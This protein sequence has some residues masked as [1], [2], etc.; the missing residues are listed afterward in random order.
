MS[1]P[2]TYCTACKKEFN[3]MSAFEHH[4]N[5]KHP[6]TTFTCNVCDLTYP[7][8]AGYRKHYQTVHVKHQHTCNSCGKS[9]AYK[10]LLIDHK[11]THSGDYP[12][13]CEEEGCGCVY[14]TKAALKIHMEVH[15]ENVHQCQKCTFV[16]D[17]AQNLKQHMMSHEKKKKCPECDF[18]YLWPIQFNRHKKAT[19]HK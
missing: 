5:E 8:Q 14:T 1:K 17:T 7:T 19:G 3:T 4:T 18:K 6:G 13:K 12:F 15:A 16:T 9:F 10:Y 11:K 2:S